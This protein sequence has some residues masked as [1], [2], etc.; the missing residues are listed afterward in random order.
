VISLKL[1]WLE[2]HQVFN[3]SKKKS[4]EM[5]I[6]QFLKSLIPS[7]RKT[8]ITDDCRVT[9]SELE[10]IA[11]PA[12]ASAEKVFSTSKFKS[13]EMKDFET[14]FKQFVKTQAGQPMII[15]ISRGLVKILES[16]DFIQDR[17]HRDFEAE[18]FV[19]G[20]SS[21]KANLL[22]ILECVHFATNYS[23]LLLNYFYLLETA[24]QN[25]DKSYVKEALSPAEI[26]HLNKKFPDFC[27][28]L[29]ILG[30]DKSKIVKMF[31]SIPDV[32]LTASTGDIVSATIG[33]DKLDPIGFRG[34]S[35]DIG[36]PI[37]HIRLIFAQRQIAEYNRNKQLKRV[38]ELRLLNLQMIQADGTD[39]KLEQEIAYIQGRV[40]GLD[41]E[42]TKMEESV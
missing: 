1:I 26:D 8:T 37:Y 13:S 38:L 41:H 34:I 12:Y 33:E 42:L 18:T 21:V 39:A 25:K 22:R 31:D 29:N 2:T 24:E 4:K 5:N 16:K 11:I 27:T 7:F 28:I 40:Q 3:N 17:I 9:Y 36:N 23:L 32:L 15:G 10:A 30:K 6:L 19:E 20:L 14:I 35:G